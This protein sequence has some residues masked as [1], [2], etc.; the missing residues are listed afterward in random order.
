LGL[1]E[2]WKDSISTGSAGG[3]HAIKTEAKPTAQRDNTFRFR[4]SFRPQMS[5]CFVNMPGGQEFGRKDV[6][7]TDGKFGA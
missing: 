6:S 5:H 7:F 1:R 2:Q 3:A 4:G